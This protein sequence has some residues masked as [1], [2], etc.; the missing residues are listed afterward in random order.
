M[1]LKLKCIK[2][3]RVNTRRRG[4]L[5]KEDRTAPSF[6]YL[7][8]SRTDTGVKEGI[9]GREVNVT[10]LQLLTEEAQLLQ[11]IRQEMSTVEKPTC[12]T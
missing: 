1:T 5:L 10:S 12:T 4:N 6:E 8:L 3:S 7:S 9:D 2:P 11:H